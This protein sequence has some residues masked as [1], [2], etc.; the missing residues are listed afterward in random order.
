MPFDRFLIAPFQSGLQTDLRPWIIPDDAFAQLQNVYI[1][2]GRVRKRFGGTYMGVGPLS[3][4]LRFQVGTIASPSSPVPGII[5][6]IGQQFSAGAQIFTVYQT[7]TPAAMLNTGA[8]TG[9]FDTSNGNF[10]ISGTG[11]SGTTPIYWYPA[12]PVM[13]LTN[14]QVGPI[15]NQPSFAF[16]TQFAYIWVAGGWTQSLTTPTWQGDYLNF[17]DACNWVAVDASKQ[18]MFVTNFQVTN[19]NGNISATDD[20]LYSYNTNAGW[21]A[22]YPYFNPAGG[23]VG[24]GPYVLTC[25]LIVVFKN[26]LVLLNTVETSNPSEGTSVN[27]WY[28][29]R[30][31][32]SFFGDPFAANAW[33]EPNV[34]DST[35][36]AGH[37]GAGGSFVDA[38][39]DEQIVSAEFIKDR[40]IV[41]FERST[42]ELAYTGN[43]MNPFAWQKLNTELGSEATF[44]S[45]PFDQQILTIGTTGIHECNGSNVARIDNKI[46]DEVFEIRQPNNGIGQV[47]GVRDYYVEQVYWTFPTAQASQT[48]PDQVLVYNYKTGSWALNDDCITVF[49]YFEQQSDLTWASSAPLTWEN[50]NATWTSGVIQAQF[51]QVLAGNQ[52][53]YVFMIQPDVSR[54]AGVMNITDISISAGIVTLTVINHSI[55]SNE[56]EYILIENVQGTTNLNGN[57]YAALFIDSNTISIT[58]TTASGT[59]TGGGTIARVSNTQILSKQWNPY[60]KQGRNVYIAKVDFLVQTT[61]GGQIT[62]DYYPS[63]TELSMIAAGQGTGSIMG[64]GILETAPYP[65][66][67]LEADQVR[68]W[69]PVYLQ[70]DGECIQLFMYLTDTQITNPIIALSDFELDAILLHT[71]PTGYHFR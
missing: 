32:F 42:W 34:T 65:D 19:M 68:V 25:R 58:S 1:F 37:V 8:G 35:G 56:V 22:F 46:P 7:G 2:R 60:D 40:L 64:T 27:S 53:G 67:P 41:Y 49:G 10:V 62:V 47:A 29:G 11:L 69:H 13:G 14:Y 26:R 3:S 30:A 63:S 45:V 44:S 71:S 20:P 4:Q 36:G 24:T 16:D 52:Q 28:S 6:D 70:T 39:T 31:R 18:Y 17:F 38:A 59:Y 57:I 5:F 33:Y 50:I 23:A 51:R 61:D 66:V 55:P 12:Q 9:T 21:A 43:Q 54:N 48:F 15:N